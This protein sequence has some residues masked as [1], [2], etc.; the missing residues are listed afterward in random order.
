VVTKLGQQL[1]KLVV[2][3]LDLVFREFG[4]R[5]NG[6]TYRKHLNGNSVIVALQRDSRA[7]ANTLRFTIDLGITSSRVLSFFNEDFDSGDRVDITDSCWRER[8]GAVFGSDDI[9]W[10][11]TSE[12]EA[13]TIAEEIRATLERDTLP[14]LI[15]I[16]SDERLRD[17][18]R[19]GRSPGLTELQRLMNLGILLRQLGPTTELDALKASLIDLASSDPALTGSVESYLESL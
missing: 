1:L 6:S 12:A 9:W 10:T 15:E 2:R 17:I 14:F 19:T 8:I 5:R 3:D 18:W 13:E 7:P 11:V 16:A 4:F